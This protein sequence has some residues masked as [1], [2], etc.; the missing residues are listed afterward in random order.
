[1]FKTAMAELDKVTHQISL[2]WLNMSHSDIGCSNYD[3]LVKLF[4]KNS[5]GN[6]TYLFNTSAYGKCTY[7]IIC[8][9]KF[10][11]VL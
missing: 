6:E 7:A 3:F 2:T 10:I 8:K 11:M 9:C 5:V 4:V 1:M